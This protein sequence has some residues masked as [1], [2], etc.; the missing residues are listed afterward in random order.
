MAAYTDRAIAQD[1]LASLQGEEA[2][3][4]VRGSGYIA[5]IGHDGNM[6][7]WRTAERVA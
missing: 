1:L 7:F 5:G 4:E 2:I 6:W 3:T